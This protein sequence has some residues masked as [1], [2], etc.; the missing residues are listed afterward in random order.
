[1]KTPPPLGIPVVDS[2]TLLDAIAADPPVFNGVPITPRFLGGLSSLDGVHPA[3]IGQALLTNE[4]VETI[5][6]H[7][8]THM[9]PISETA[10][11]FIAVTD[12]FVDKDGDGR[13]RGRFGAGLL[14]TLGPF[15]GIS[16]DQDDL[17]P[18]PFWVGIDESRGD[19]FIERLLALQGKD[20]QAAS[21]WEREDAI[22]AVKHIFAIVQ[23]ARTK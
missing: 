13:V 23:D 12:P 8:Q 18:D 19:R 1:M 15:L 14:E 16:G 4:F 7:F 3:D 22:D 9:P 6:A 17:T 20:P 2:K 11:N 5:N 10:L 21:E